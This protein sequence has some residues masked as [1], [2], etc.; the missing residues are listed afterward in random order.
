MKPENST[1]EKDDKTQVENP[2]LFNPDPKLQSITNHITE[3]RVLWS[4]LDSNGHVNN[5]NYQF[6]LDE[7]RIQALEEEGF[8]IA[9]MR[10]ANVG[11][12]IQKAEIIYS[13]PLGH[14][15]TVRVETTFA[16]FKGFRGK[17]IQTIWRKSDSELVCKAVFDALFF[18]FDKRRPWKMPEEFGSKYRE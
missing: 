10:A 16:Q 4:Q 18:D 5:G 2:I 8:M 1:L 12:V 6:Y 17:V 3:I 14:P 15:E 7:A 13:K 9:A 11:P